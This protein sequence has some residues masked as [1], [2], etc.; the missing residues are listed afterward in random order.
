MQKLLAL[1][2]PGASGYA[3]IITRLEEKFG[4]ARK[5]LDFQLQKL[6]RITPVQLGQAEALE[7]SNRHGACIPS[8]AW[9]AKAMN[10]PLPTRIILWC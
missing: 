9:R 7:E 2:P 5:T 10:Q 1:A 4:G 6:K 8:W 3:M